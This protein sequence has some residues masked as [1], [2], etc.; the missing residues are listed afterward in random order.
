MEI[1][2]MRQCLDGVEQEIRN[3]LEDLPLL[4][5]DQCGF[6]RPRLNIDS[7]LGN[8][9][10]VEVKCGSRQIDQ[11]NLFRLRIQA[12]EGKASGGDLPQAAQLTIRLIQIFN[13]PE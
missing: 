2:G 4:C 8:L 7:F 9:L 10:M 11:V 5:A 12:N 3:R 6:G 1:P 13:A